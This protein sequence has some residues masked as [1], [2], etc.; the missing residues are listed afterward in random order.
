MQH[1]RLCLSIL[2]N[3]IFKKITDRQLKKKR[4]NNDNDFLEHTDFI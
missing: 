2:N 3:K 4:K 1:C